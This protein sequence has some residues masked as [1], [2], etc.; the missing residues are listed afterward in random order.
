MLQFLVKFL[1]P[2]CLLLSAAV[3]AQTAADRLVIERYNTQNGLTHAHVY[4]VFQ[5]SRGFI[6]L[7]TGDALMLYDG[8]IFTPVMRWE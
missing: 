1:I 8:I 6:W 2:G 5:D 7:V 3:G 4:Q